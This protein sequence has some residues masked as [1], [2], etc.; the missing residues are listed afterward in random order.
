VSEPKVIYLGPACEAETSEGRTWA[1]DSP[2][3]DCECG[4]RPVQ[5]VLGETFDRMK[6]ERDS[7]QQRL[8]SA[9]QRIDEAE[10]LIRRAI[11]ALEGDGWKQLE[12]DLHRFVHPSTKAAAKADAPLTDEGTMPATKHHSED[13][14]D[15]VGGLKVVVDPTLAPDEMR[16]VQ[17][18]DAERERL[19]AIIE[20]YPN[21]DPLE[22]NAALRKIQL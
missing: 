20:N 17:P 16:L 10:D 14:L 2:W 18:A 3:P 11:A 15:M 4:Q 5:Y 19:L 12:A 22:Y 7:L 9:D 1:E 21:G 6:A 8:N 13:S